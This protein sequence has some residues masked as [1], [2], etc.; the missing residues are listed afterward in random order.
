MKK[1]LKK[2]PKFRNED[3]EAEFCWLCCGE[4]YDLKFPC[5]TC[6]KWYCPCDSIHGRECDICRGCGEKNPANRGAG[7]P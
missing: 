3:E 1:R 4:E 6:G 2:I 5:F 7:S